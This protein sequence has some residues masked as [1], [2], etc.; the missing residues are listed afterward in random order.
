FDLIG[1]PAKPVAGA[2]GSGARA[3]YNAARAAAVRSAGR[4]QG[5]ECLKRQ[6]QE[7][8]TDHGALRVGQR[9]RSQQDVN[10]AV[11]T[12]MTTGK[13]TDKVG[14]YGTRQFHY[15]GENGLTVIIETEGRNA[16]KAVTTFGKKP[17]GKQ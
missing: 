6:G 16:G 5:R 17:G 11:E 12:A 13:I 1:A 2:V 10:E 14:K 15:Q 7:A 4:Q 3:A 8:L 9:L